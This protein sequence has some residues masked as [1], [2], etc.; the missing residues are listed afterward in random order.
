MEYHYRKG[1]VQDIAGLR[2]LGLNSYGQFMK[3]LTPDNWERLHAFLRNEKTY[4][5]LLTKAECFI[6]QHQEVIVG[7]AFLIPRGN[8]TDIF[9]GDWCYIRMIGVHTAHSARGIGKKLTQMCIG[10]ARTSNEKVIG[11][12]TSEFMDAARHIYEALGFQKIKE[13]E[14]R[15]GKT[16]WLYA[17]DLTEAEYI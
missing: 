11:L 10:Y 3:I 4:T 14:Q 9:P 5:D 1:S 17:L 8:P 7:M 12:H 2:E 13:L 16:Y 15:L 6:C